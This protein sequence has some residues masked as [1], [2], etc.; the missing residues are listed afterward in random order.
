MY[1]QQL[2]GT[3]QEQT[4]SD[5]FYTPKWIFDALD[6]TFDIDVCSPPGGPLHTPCRHYYTM[7]DDGLAQPWHG[8]V[9]MNPPYSKPQPWIDRWLEHG[10]GVALIPFAKSAWFVQLWE[11]SNVALTYVHDM[12]RPS[13]NFERN[14]T[15]AQIMYPVC[16]AAI[17]STS[18]T[19]LHKLGKVR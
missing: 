15:E 3:P 16:A 5:D 13:L 18:I 19:A 12:N 10:N 7:Y 11:R 8:L 14:G 4:T 17:G 9:W 1:Q 6:I 2:F